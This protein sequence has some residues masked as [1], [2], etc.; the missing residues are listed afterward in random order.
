[1]ARL[2]EWLN[3]KWKAAVLLVTGL[4]ALLLWSN[5]QAVESYKDKQD[6]TANRRS[7]SANDAAADA[8]RLSPDDI[9]RRMQSK[10]W[11]RD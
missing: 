10:G 9:A 6:E 1:M 4:I 7:S 5:R 3:A 8:N 11:Y 2:I